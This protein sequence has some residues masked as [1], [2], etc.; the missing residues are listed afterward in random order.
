[1]QW[2]R[3]VQFVSAVAMPLDVTTAFGTTVNG[4]WAD[5]EAMASDDVSLAHQAGRRVLFSVPMIALIPRVYEAAAWLLDEVCRDVTDEPAECDWYYW[6]SKPVYAACI[7]SDV[8]RRYLFDRCVL[9]IERGM[10]VVNLDEIMTSIGLM[11]RDARG[12]GFCARCLEGFRRHLRGAGDAGLAA[13]D[14]HA[15]RHAIRH[16]DALYGR[17]RQA[18]ERDAFAVMTGF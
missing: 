6:E 5:P 15:L 9:G 16:D 3:Q 17:Y 7:Y 1:M 12:S 2:Y 4:M 10:D 18:Q 11:N 13:L 14:D 8:F